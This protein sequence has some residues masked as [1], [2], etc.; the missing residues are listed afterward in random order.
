MKAVVPMDLRQRSSF[1]T[2]VTRRR[3]PDASLLISSTWPKHFVL[4]LTLLISFAHAFP[5][6]KAQSEPQVILRPLPGE[7]YVQFHAGNRKTGPCS[8]GICT[9]A[10]TKEVPRPKEEDTAVLNTAS[11]GRKEVPFRKPIPASDYI[12]KPEEVEHVRNGIRKRRQLQQGDLLAVESLQNPVAVLPGPAIRSDLSDPS[13]TQQLQ[14]IRTDEIVEVRTEV[15]IVTSGPRLVI[16]PAGTSGVERPQED[17]SSIH[18]LPMHETFLVDL[19]EPHLEGSSTENPFPVAVKKRN[20]Q[21]EH[22]GI[23][24]RSSSVVPRRT[25][26]TSTTTTA[27]PTTTTSTTPRPS[28]TTRPPSPTTFIPPV[29][30]A[31]KYSSAET[32]SNLGLFANIPVPM[33]KDRD[34][35]KLQTSKDT[36][37][38]ARNSFFQGDVRDSDFKSGKGPLDD[39]TLVAAA[40][41]PTNTKIVVKEV[42]GQ[43][44][45]YEYL[46]YEYDPENPTADPLDSVPDVDPAPAAPEKAPKAPPSPPRNDRKL[47]PPPR[48]QFSEQPEPLNKVL[49][50][51]RSS[52]QGDSGPRII[53]QATTAKTDPPPTTIPRGPPPPQSQFPRDQPPP[54]SQPQ[55]QQFGFQPLPPIQQFPAPP[56]FQNPAQQ[57]FPGQFQFQPPPPPPPPARPFPQIPE[58]R[59]PENTRFPP[60]NDQTPAPPHGVLDQFFQPPSF[61]QNF[62]P[63]RF[64][65]P[66]QQG[67]PPQQGPPPQ[68]KLPPN[69][70]SAPGSQFGFERQP[71]PVFRP[72]PEAPVFR[73]QDEEDQFTNHEEEFL[74]NQKDFFGHTDQGP[75]GP[76]E[77]V[78]ETELPEIEALETTLPATTTVSTTTT[79]EA[80]TTTTTTEATTTTTTTEATTTTTEE[81]TT[82]E[83]FRGRERPSFL[84]SLRSRDRERPAFR[85]APRTRTRPQAPSRSRTSS[86]S[87]KS[88]RGESTADEPEDEENSIAVADDVSTSTARTFGRR[89]PSKP[90]PSFTRSRNQ[91]PGLDNKASSR[92]SPSLSRQRGRGRATEA[93]PEEEVKEGEAEAEAPAEEVTERTRGLPS[94][95]RFR[96]GESRRTLPT[97]LF[98][99]RGRQP[100][101]TTTTQAPAEEGADEEVPSEDTAAAGTEEEAPTEEGPAAEEPKAEEKSGPVSLQDLLKRRSRVRPGIPGITRSRSDLFNRRRGPETTTTTTTPAPVEEEVGDTTP[102]DTGAAGEGLGALEDGAAEEEVA[103]DP[104]EVAQENQPVV[105]GGL[106]ARLRQRK[107]GSLFNPGQT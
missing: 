54:Q 6:P 75:T 80:T 66:P 37:I 103:T 14:P 57:Q 97:S 69:E 107:P 41:N 44:Y 84:S 22:S 70:G 89:R 20:N 52:F 31:P 106:L 27:A 49:S 94:R 47:P 93:P 7:E 19:P 26:T 17:G 56:T 77:E 86:F 65:P 46:Y 83:R 98:R 79:T 96:P 13:L 25:T 3:H 81:P 53:E 95:G 29:K 92:F 21:D 85:P 24:H 76:P 10:T 34:S 62:P 78:H 48:S 71:A 43:L 72:E 82:T 39:K 15:S 88:R 35:R 23:Q 74:D 59:L 30:A 91:I 87:P 67:I 9:L 28:P 36:A 1:I 18:V 5:R 2:K 101:T 11:G 40:S 16:H 4:I 32:P 68:Q 42:N 102:A 51:Q 64:E 55:F 33:T 12:L 100:T 45:E 99:S 38:A 8:S 73:P 90:T 50:D 60:R 63:P 61:Q 105:G 104:P 58:E